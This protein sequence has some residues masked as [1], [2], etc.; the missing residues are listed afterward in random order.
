[1]K[2]RYDAIVVGA[3]P[4]GSVA[5]GTLARGGASVL[6]LDRREVVGEPVRCGELIR[7]DSLLPFA[8]AEG[9][10]VLQNF[11]EYHV[12]APGGFRI[13]F[14]EAG[15]GVLLDRRVFDKELARR[16]VAAGA[17]LRTSASVVELARDGEAVT[18][19]VVEDSGGARRAVGARLVIA[20]DGVA[21]RIARLAG[22]DTSLGLGEM[23]ATVSCIVEHQSW[24]DRECELHF[25]HAAPGGYLWVFPRRPGAANVGAGVSARLAKGRS[26]LALLREF[27]A[28]RFP[29]GR[30]TR[31]VAGG[32]PIARPAQRFCWPGLLLAGDAARQVNPLTGAG[33][34]TSM[35]AGALAGAA[36][37][38]LTGGGSPAE[39]RDLYEG[40]WSQR[41]GAFTERSLTARRQLDRVGDE[42]LDAAARM[43]GEHRPHQSVAQ[44]IMELAATA[45]TL[46]RGRNVGPP[47]S[48]ASQ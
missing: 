34:F 2:P 41:F 15:L 45:E 4:A 16:A 10:W 43:L 37:L 33:I 32:I 6:L 48:A 29:G 8:E 21:S 42:D 12:V 28:R 13:R 19:V 38:K 11:D 44:S 23:A 27:V 30:L 18:G 7:R 26:A 24:A 17:E 22:I 35:S 3:G 31:V 25:G 9:P 20:A 40:G 36:G 5:A 46:R 1:V 39:A 14:R 47:L